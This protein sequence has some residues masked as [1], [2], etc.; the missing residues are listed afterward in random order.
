M[1]VMTANQLLE[2]LKADR[3]RRFREQTATV[4]KRSDGFYIRYY[5]DRDGGARTKVT[6]RLCDL[7]TDAVT[8]RTRQRSFMTG[9]NNAQQITLKS[10][11][12]A[13]ALTIGGF[14]SATYLPWVKTNKRFSTSR[15]YEKLWNQYLKDELD[16]KQLSN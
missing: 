1:L 12:E 5:A 10:P 3:K 15:G 6:E 7:D 8:L 14:W 13:P 2:L 11:T 4:V 16:A 9:I